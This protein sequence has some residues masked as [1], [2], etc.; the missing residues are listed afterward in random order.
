MKHPDPGVSWESLNKDAGEQT[1]RYN[2][3]LA[4]LFLSK[5]G[6]VAKPTFE[7]G[8]R[9]RMSR[10]MLCF[11]LCRVASKEKKKRV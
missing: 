1:S 2:S 5:E 10:R 4:I 8:L 7:Y 3:S 6:V 11:C 9:M